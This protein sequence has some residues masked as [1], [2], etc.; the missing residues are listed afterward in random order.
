M[1]RLASLAA[2]CVVSI[3]SAQA[4]AAAPTKL[5]F[6]RAASAQECPAEAQLRAAVVARL[7]HDPFASEAHDALHVEITTDAGKLRGHFSLERGGREIGSQTLE[8]TGTPAEHKAGH[9]SSICDELVDALALEVALV[10]EAAD[11]TEAKTAAE[12]PAVSPPAIAT[13]EPAPT[14]AAA[15][16]PL[17]WSL[18]G[19]AGGRASVGSW[20][21]AAVAPQIGVEARRGL[22]GLGLDLRVDVIPTLDVESARATLVRPSASLLP[23]AHGRWIYGCAVATLG[24]TVVHGIDVASSRE[25]S[26]PYAALGGRAG[27]DLP[28]AAR[29][30]L[31]TFVE[32]VGV[33]TPTTV[34]LDAS[35]GVSPTVSSRAWDG[36]AG[37]LL[38]GS[39]F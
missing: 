1:A 34:R 6:H 12:P 13:A 30:H 37:I 15:P 9:A 39:I 17:P 38:S 23:C 4:H 7:G 10:F 31:L 33:A 32:M 19:S 26:S 11:A 35:D 14:R 16:S 36:A 24:A 20:A 8:A 18:W 29:L 28:L 27:L 22:F 25:A 3:G 2:V 5:D 21:E